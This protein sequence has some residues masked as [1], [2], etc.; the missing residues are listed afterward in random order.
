VS[1]DKDPGR[2]ALIYDPSRVSWAVA[3][4]V[5]M[6]PAS[7]ARIA[8]YMIVALV[9][10]TVVYARL[11]WIS[12]TVDGQGV[13]RTSAKVV[14]VRAEVGGR[15]AVLSVKD[16][17]AV[18]K[19]QLLLE[20]E[21]QVAATTLERAKKLI[22]DLDALVKDESNDAVTKAG[23]LAQQPMQLN[24]SSMVRERSSLAEAVNALY[25]ALRG[26]ADVPALSAA[27]SAEA[28]A[29]RTK[30]K[31]IKS[32]GLSA[33]LANELA[34]LEKLVIQKS[35]S[36][37]GRREQA[38]QQVN[39]AR[40]ALEVQIRSFE[41]QLEVHIR[42]QH[43]LAPAD[44]IAHKVAVSG[45]N[46]LVAQNTTLL[47]IIPDGGN[48]IAEVNIANKDIAQL[49]V[50][51]PVGIHIDAM[52]YQDYGSLPAHIAEIPPDATVNQQGTQSSYVIKLSLDRTTV[53]GGHEAKPV[54]LG[55]TLQAQ[56]Q[57]RKRTL[58]D[59]AIREIFSL[60][61]IL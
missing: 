33:E 8:I 24:I 52:P 38:V 39:S 58:L 40:G 48:L 29:A 54:L 56:V 42:S 9:F 34:D 5:S 32:Q 16:G 51:M 49:K 27:D 6:P 45:A 50:G 2:D 17:Q 60:K 61:D 13:I 20:F 19:N 23:M 46:E 18:K 41:Q 57:I 47:E 21:D 44:G 4:S 28:G 55:M 30:I 36:I 14:P 12:M 59:L 1:D 22:K 43:V 31:K 11:T 7:L 10:A 15:I 35:V 37:R 53:N 26:V 25:Q 3:E